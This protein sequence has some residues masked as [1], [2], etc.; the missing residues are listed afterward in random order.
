MFEMERA[1]YVVYFSVDRTGAAKQRWPDRFY[2]SEA[3]DCA[4]SLAKEGR[5]TKIVRE[6]DHV[7]V[8]NSVD[9]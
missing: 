2:L 7:E 9:N 8:W 1:V 6:D 4:K 5:Y 3:L